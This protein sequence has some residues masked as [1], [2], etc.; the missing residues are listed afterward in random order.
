MSLHVMTNKAGEADNLLAALERG[1]YDHQF[2]SAFFLNRKL[3]DGQLE[4]AE[5]ANATINCLP[6]SNRWGKTTLLSHRHTHKHVYKLG[7]EPFYMGPDYV[8]DP[9]KFMRLRYH[10]IHTAEGWDTT[11]LVWD[12]MHKILGESPRLSALVSDA[13]RS[14]PPKIVFAFGSVWKFKT[15]GHDASGIDG[16]S[17]YHISIDEAGW[18]DGLEVMMNNVI[19]VRVADVNG[20]IDLVGTMKP[21]I[22]R[23]FYKYSVRSSSYCGRGVTFAHDTGAESEENGGNMRL[24]ASI[25]KYLREFYRREAVRG[26]TLSDELR[27]NLAALGITP[28]ELADALKGGR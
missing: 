24:D 15:L 10:T 7:G 27:E 16:N 20:T 6:T 9:E 12:E 13:P 28:D 5:N 22:S 3:H 17:F 18:I 2:F 26:N 19:R 4:Y 23:D 25:R 8:I 11:A 1:R 14:L 21:G